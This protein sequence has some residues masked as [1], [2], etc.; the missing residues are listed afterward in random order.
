MI[1]WPWSKRI[2]D[3]IR[4]RLAA[5]QRLKGIVEDGR[6]ITKHTQDV[7]REVVLND[8]TLTAKRVFAG[9]EA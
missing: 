4:H 2:E 9:R 6:E 5:E 8:W 7:T 1:K 3:Q